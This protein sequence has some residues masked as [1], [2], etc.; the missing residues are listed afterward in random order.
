MLNLIKAFFR[1][2]AVGIYLTSENKLTW[3]SWAIG[4]FFLVFFSMV[5]F[6]TLGGTIIR[7]ITAVGGN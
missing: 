6:A 2:S 5:F 7:I 4:S 3:R 1:S